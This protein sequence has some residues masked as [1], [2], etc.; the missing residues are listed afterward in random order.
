[1]KAIRIHKYGGPEV[2]QYEEAPRPKPQA[3]E[4]LIR[5]HA[6]GVNPIDRKIRAGYLKD[7]FSVK[8]PL[9]FGWEVPGTVEKVGPSAPTFKKGDEVF[10]V[11][12]S[13]GRRRLRRIHCG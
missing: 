5:V 6:A 4:V 8:F 2:L 12:R 7:F 3:G 11:G 9:I 1:M 10:A 13:K